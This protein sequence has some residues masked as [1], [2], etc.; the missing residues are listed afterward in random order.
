[1][2]DIQVWEAAVGR[3][4]S[5]YTKGGAQFPGRLVFHGARWTVIEHINAQNIQYT[6]YV[7]SDEIA[8]VVLRPERPA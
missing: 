7:L 1:M 5:I 2:T 4:V 8:A 3:T 6:N